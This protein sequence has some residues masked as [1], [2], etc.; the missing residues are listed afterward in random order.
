MASA[1]GE[2]VSRALDARSTRTSRV[3]VTLC[4]SVRV[5]ECCA[6]ETGEARPGSGARTERVALVERWTTTTGDSWPMSAAHDRLDATAR[7]AAAEGEGVAPCTRAVSTRMT[8]VG[9][10]ASGLLTVVPN[11]TGDGGTEYVRLVMDVTDTG[12]GACTV[13]GRLAAGSVDDDRF[14]SMLPPP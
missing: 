6:V 12:L 2:R 14:F 4:T 7:L 11:W 5:F 1:S 13:T 3:S 8:G 10:S 9:R